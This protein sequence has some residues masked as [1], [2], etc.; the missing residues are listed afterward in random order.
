MSNAI[1]L[2]SNSSIGGAGSGTL[3]GAISGS[4][5]NL[6]KVGASTITLSGNN[7]YS[8]STTV[9]NGILSL[10]ATTGLGNTTGTT[11]ANGA[12]LDIS[13]NSGT[14]GNTNSITING[15]GISGAGALT[16]TGTSDVLR[17]VSL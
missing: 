11:V 2:G 3:N 15:T 4:G 7:T 13:F 10:G 8:G 9:S 17:T 5:D 16:F 6:T 14:L 12:A 1:T